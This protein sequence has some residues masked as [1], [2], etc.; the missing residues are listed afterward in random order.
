MLFKFRNYIYHFIK[1]QY[2]ELNNQQDNFVDDILKK[3]KAMTSHTIEVGLDQE[4]V[5]ISELI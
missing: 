5:K 4:I 2:F 1:H 3:Q